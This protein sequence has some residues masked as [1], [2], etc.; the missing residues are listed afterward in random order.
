VRALT[1]VRIVA[2]PGTSPIEGTIV[3][4]DGRIEAVGAGAEIPPGAVVHPLPGRTVYA[5]LIEP[6]LRIAEPAIA[7]GVTDG[8]GK[9]RPELRAVDVLP[10]GDELVREMRGAGFT[11]AHLALGA[12]IF[13]GRTAVV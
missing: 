3:I 11:T 8:N 12:G 7:G 13:R 9:V 2:A 1:G 6:Y 10:L 4:R 5:G